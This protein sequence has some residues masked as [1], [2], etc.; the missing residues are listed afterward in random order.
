MLRIDKT[1]TTPF[2]PQSDG[3]V[4]RLNRT[5]VCMLSMY[6]AEDQKDWD[7]HLTCMM[8][9]YRATPQGSSQ[10][11]PNLLMLGRETELPIDLMVGKPPG[12]EDRSDS[13]AE[14]VLKM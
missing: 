9:V 6:V 8:F 5:I 10:C 3:M 12:S 11:S 4:E 14:Y 13:Q 1:R 7:L 2:H